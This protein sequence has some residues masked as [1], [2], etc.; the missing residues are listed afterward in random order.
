MS[1]SSAILS[2][3]TAFRNPNGS[4]DEWTQN[5]VK[6]TVSFSKIALAEIGYILVIPFAV[7]ETAFSAIAKLFTS[8]LP[9]DSARHDTMSKWLLSS[10]F[11][12]G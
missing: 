3:V 5:P 2:Y 12:N 4:E 7:V 10:I 8:F 11:S 9:I 6:K 1:A